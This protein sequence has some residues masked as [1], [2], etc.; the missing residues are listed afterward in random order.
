MERQGAFKINVAPLTS[1]MLGRFILS[2]L[3]T[4]EAWVVP[5]YPDAPAPDYTEDKAKI[6]KALYEHGI[7]AAVHRCTRRLGREGEVDA[8]F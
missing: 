1:E 7:I 2:T 6:V 3:E 4:T 8:L 5:I